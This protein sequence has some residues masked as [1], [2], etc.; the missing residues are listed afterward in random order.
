[1]HFEARKRL[2]SFKY[3]FWSYFNPNQ[4]IIEKTKREIEGDLGSSRI[5]MD[6]FQ[7]IGE[8][9]MMNITQMERGL[10][11]FTNRIKGQK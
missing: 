5:L 2:V 9:E 8:I 10:M 4:A 6:V 7:Q 11:V 1:M 3:Q